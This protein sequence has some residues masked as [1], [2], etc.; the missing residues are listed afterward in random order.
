MVSRQIER[1]D[2]IK[3][4]KSSTADTRTCEW[5]TVTKE[6]LLKASE[7][8]IDDVNKGMLYFIHKL[9]TAAVNHDTTKISHIDQFHEDFKTGFEK[10]DWW[11]MHQK[12]ERHHFKTPEFIQDDINLVDVIEQIVD[13]VMAGMAR[14]GEYRY[15]PLPDELLQKA[16]KNTAKLL[17]DNVEV[18]T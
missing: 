2:M 1:K 6:Q 4:K 12:E 7:Q 3:I 18:E 17:L 9:Q 5:S 13:G 16:Y 10:T 14:S 11:E 15:E 8:H